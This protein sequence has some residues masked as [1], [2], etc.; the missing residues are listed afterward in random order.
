MPYSGAVICA[1]MH[2]YVFSVRINELFVPLFNMPRAVSRR[3]LP[4]LIP[5]VKER[6]GTDLVVMRPAQIVP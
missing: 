6:G 5:Q 2:L 3:E 4:T 1:A